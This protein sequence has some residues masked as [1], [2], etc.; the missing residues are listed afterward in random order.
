MPCTVYAGWEKG[1]LSMTNQEKEQKNA[2]NKQ[3]KKN[4][5]YTNSIQKYYMP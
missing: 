5:E 3:E 4:S 1:G 2:E